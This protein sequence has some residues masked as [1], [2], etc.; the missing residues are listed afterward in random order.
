MH[1]IYT[2]VTTLAAIATGFS[3]A[4]NFG[5]AGSVKATADRLRISR[6]WMVPFGILLA[7]GAVGLLLGMAVPML[8][9]A[10]AIGLI[11][12]FICAVAAHLR[13]HD[14]RIGGALLFLLLAVAALVTDVSCRSLW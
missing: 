9:A 13:V 12:Y 8:G 14:R 1:I 4:M 2:V 3:A 10:A 6:R 5:G 11:L 7:T